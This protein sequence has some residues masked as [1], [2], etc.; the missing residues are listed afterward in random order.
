MP[1]LAELLAFNAP[2]VKFMSSITSLSDPTKTLLWHKL[3]FNTKKAIIH[4]LAPMCY[5]VLIAASKHGQSL[6]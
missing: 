5:F 2:P 1:T 4:Q 6:R 3:A